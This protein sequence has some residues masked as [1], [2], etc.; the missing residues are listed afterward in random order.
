M[1]EEI[2]QET[3]SVDYKSSNNSLKDLVFELQKDS[4]RQ[5]NRI[6]FLEDTIKMILK[7]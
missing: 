1:S 4:K 7:L 2:K 5:M 3:A 6:I